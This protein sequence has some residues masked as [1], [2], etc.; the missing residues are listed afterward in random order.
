VKKRLIIQSALL[1]LLPLFIFAQGVNYFEFNP[2][3]FKTKSLN[4]SSGGLLYEIFLPANEFLGGADFWFDN[5]GSS[6]L[7]IFEL[8]DQNN[9]LIT[10]KN[11]TIP[12]I[13]PVS[14]GQRVH[15]GWN[16]QVPVVSNDKYR[17]KISSALPQL[18]I[19]YADRIK[20]LGHNEP[21]ISDYINGAAEVNGEEQQF[22][23]KY[24]LYESNESSVPL[25]SNIAWAVISEN[26][27]RI[28]FNTNEPVDFRIEYGLSGQDYSQTTNWTGEYQFC[29]EGVATCNLF[30]NVIPNTAY[31]Y[32][33]T[34]NDSWGN[35]NQVNGTFESGQIQT[36]SPTGEPTLT[37]TP[38]PTTSL[39]PT[40]SD[41]TPPTSSPTPLPADNIPP[42]IS[43]LRVVLLTDTSVEIAWTTN[44]VA[45]SHLLISTPFLITITDKSDPTMELEH[46]LKI[47]GGLGAN[48]A[49]VATVTSIDQ[50]SNKSQ[51]KISFTTLPPIISSN[52]SSPTPE[53]SNQS[54][55]Q[56]NQVTPSSFTS[57]G[58]VQWDQSSGGGGGVARDGYRVDIFDQEGHLVKTVNVSAGSYDTGSL[59][60][61]KGDYNVIVYA[62]KG[63]GVFEKIDQPV[64]LEVKSFWQRLLGFW[65]VLI[66][67]LA[68]IGYVFWKNYKSKNK[69]SQNIKP[70]LP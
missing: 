46:L 24:A 34:V 6:G 29:S 37:L 52:L 35:Q 11:I 39:T 61:E 38:T 32:T 67:A 60:L 51:S 69:T 15:V 56:S 20:F 59:G 33:L 62:N 23:F 42:A 30:V 41:T 43:N 68:G 40:P 66:L 5:A 26:Q 13:D 45:N 8:R 18:Q 25:I 64:T 50:G 17:I 48:V 12:H 58:L 9:N 57:G 16:S 22:S 27:M 4:V 65:P 1:F 21:H 55:Q 70:V 14:G 3:Y 44:E 7:A 19:Y 10:S 31:Q 49:Y 63:E 47:N 36:P 2:D 54:N 53:P 28:D